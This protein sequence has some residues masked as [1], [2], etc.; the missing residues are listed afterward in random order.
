MNRRPK[1]LILD[2]IH[3]GPSAHRSLIAELFRPL[4]G[5][6]I[7]RDIIEGTD[8]PCWTLPVLQCKRCDWRWHP[9]TNTRPKRCPKCH[10]PGWEWERGLWSRVMEAR[11]N[12]RKHRRDGTYRNKRL[13]KVKGKRERMVV[14][15]PSERPK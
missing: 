9:V 1:P 13:K 6:E 10:S 15:P 5:C 2:V 11:K 7:A 8:I 12:P 14:K 4:A 3:N